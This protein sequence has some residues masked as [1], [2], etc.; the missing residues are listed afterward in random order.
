MD[1]KVS[2]FIETNPVGGPAGQ[3]EFLNAAA[4]IET[5]LRPRLLLESL[6]E[7]ELRLGRARS[8]H[9]GPRPIDLDILLIGQQRIA[10]PDLTVPHPRMHF[11][12]FVLAPLVDIAPDLSHPDGWTI[13]QRWNQL[14]SWPHYLAL[15]GPIGSGKTTLARRIAARLK[16]DLIEDPFDSVQMTEL[17][18]ANAVERESMQR[19]LLSSR[20]DLLDLQRWQGTRPAW[21]ISDF[22]LA[23]SLAFW[24]AMS[25]SEDR[26]RHRLAVMRGNSQI[27]APT[28]VIWLDAPSSV[29]AR[30][31][32]ARGPGEAPLDEEFPSRQQTGFTELFRGPLSVPFYRPSATSIE[33]LTEEI[34]LVAQAIEG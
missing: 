22:W 27:L 3:G 24:D 9:W 31:V 5:I 26:E 10:E 15:T 23:Q 16:A 30:R 19:G 4:E 12:R 17:F 7:I 32:R 29:L 21:V 1:K 33:D 18:D 13:S 14:C 11:R 28:L 20:R 6:S 8:E 34:L 25:E 2:R